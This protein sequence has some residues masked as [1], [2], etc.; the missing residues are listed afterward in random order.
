MMLKEVFEFEVLDPAKVVTVL[1]T[2]LPSLKKKKKKSSTDD[3]DDLKLQTTVLYASLLKRLKLLTSG[4]SDAFTA[5]Q[6]ELKL[7]EIFTA[8]GLQTD[9]CLFFSLNYQL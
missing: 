4:Y 7:C 1:S 2:H 9:F 6:A 8:K 3:D 5:T